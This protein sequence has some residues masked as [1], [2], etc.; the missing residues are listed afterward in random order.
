MFSLTTPISWKAETDV[1]ATNFTQDA[2]LF[3]R[4]PRKDAFITK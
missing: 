2:S 3:E 4:F 1:P